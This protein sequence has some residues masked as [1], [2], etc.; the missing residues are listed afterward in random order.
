MIVPIQK[1]GIGDIIF[2][3]T[4]VRAFKEPVRWVVEE[5]FIDGLQRAYPDIGFVVDNFNVRSFG[6]D[7]MRRAIRVTWDVINWG[8]NWNT[9]VTPIGGRSYV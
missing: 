9:K 4:L 5:Q 8:T 6:Y 3:M 1:W 2:E 7:D